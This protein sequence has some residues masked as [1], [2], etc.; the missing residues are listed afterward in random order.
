MSVS[1]YAGHLTVGCAS[2]IIS[3]QGK[4]NWSMCSSVTDRQRVWEIMRKWV[5]DQAQDDSRNLFLAPGHTCPIFSGTTLISLNLL[6]QETISWVAD[7]FSLFVH[8]CEIAIY[9]FSNGKHLMLIKHLGYRR[10]HKISHRSWH[11]LRFEK[12]S[13]NIS[14]TKSQRIVILGCWN[15]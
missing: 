8:K 1:V 6:H 4:S 15:G 13:L 12:I 11:P 9:F 7:V 3:L 2:W 5:I 10:F 14:N